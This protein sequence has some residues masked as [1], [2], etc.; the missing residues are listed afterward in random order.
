MQ[1]SIASLKQ[2]QN[3]RQTGT[4]N[5]GEDSTIELDNISL[6]APTD[7]T[8]CGEVNQNLVEEREPCETE[9]TGNLDSPGSSTIAKSTGNLSEV[10]ALFGR[11]ADHNSENGISQQG[12]RNSNTQNIGHED[13]RCWQ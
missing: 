11:P 6:H 3:N 12:S 5:F 13:G 8:F 4:P 10:A 2:S 7:I 1:N 9:L